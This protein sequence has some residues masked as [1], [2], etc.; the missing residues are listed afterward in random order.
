MTVDLARVRTQERA[1]ARFDAESRVAS[2]TSS[3]PVALP[4]EASMRKPVFL[5]LL[6]ML[7]LVLVSAAAEAQSAASATITGR[8]TDPQGAV[9]GSVTV[10]AV[11]TETGIIRS[12]QTTSDGLYNIPNLAP[13]NYNVSVQASGF[14]KAAANNVHLDVGDSRDVN[15]ALKVGS[16]TT[17]VEVSG[18]VP[19]IETTKTDV[20]MVVTSTDIEKLPV[21]QG[22]G[23]GA[24]DYQNLAYI[25]PGVKAD[26]ST[27]TNGS[28]LGDVI[29]PGSLN[30]R[31]N[32]TFVDGGNVID[33]VDSGRDG[34][35]ASVDEVDQFQVLTNNY[36]AEYGQAGGVILNVN[37]KSGKNQLHGTGYM[38]FRGRNLAASNFFYNQSL[39]LAPLTG[40]TAA[41]GCKDLNADGTLKDLNGC[42]R[43]PFHRKEGGFTLGGPLVKDRVFWF[44][45]FEDV[46]AGAPLILNPTP[47]TPSGITVNSPI[48][49]LLASGR[50]DVRLNDKNQLM[51]RYN[52]ERFAQ[53]NTTAQIGNAITPDSLIDSLFHSNGINVAL[54]SSLTPRLV[55]EARFFRLWYLTATPDHTTL[56]GEQFASYYTGANFL[57]PQG[58][59]NKRYQYLDNLTWTHGAHQ[60]KTGFN[61][62]YYP[63]YSLFTQFHFGQYGDFTGCGGDCGS[64]TDFTVGI[65]PGQVRSKDNI[66]GF[67]GQDTWKV[68]HNL[69]VNYG[70]RYD[71]EAGA[72]RGGP[73]NG[74][75]SGCQQGNAIIPACSSDKNNFQ[76]RVG[77]SYSVGSTGRTLVKGGF[78]EVTFLAYNNVVLDSRNFD[79]ENLFTAFITD[80]TVL[81]QF[82][83]YPSAASLAPFLPVP[84]VGPFGRVRPIAAN[85]KNPEMRMVNF[86][87][88]HQFTDTL[89][90]EVDYI[91]QFGSG[92]FGERDTNYPVVT[93]DPNHSGFSYFASVPSN[94]PGINPNDRPDPRFTNIRTQENS[95]K[96]HYNGLI[97]SA[98]KRMSNHIQF[99]GSYT[100]SH[101]LTN[102]EDFFGLSEPGDPRNVGADFGPAFNDARHALNF[103]VV[104]DT[105]KLVSTHLLGWA[106]NDWS[107]DFIGQFQSG[108]P[109]PVSTG[110]AAFRGERFFGSGNETQQRPDLLPDGTLVTN[111]VPS[112]NGINNDISENGAA[113][114]GCG[115]ACQNTWVAPAGASSRG[116]VDPY[117]GDIVDFKSPDGNLERNAGLGPAFGRLDFSIQKSF[118]FI[119]SHE[120]WRLELRAD[121]FN[122]LN[123]SNF[124][125][126]N[127]NPNVLGASF[128][129]VTGKYS[130]FDG[131]TLN[132][133]DFHLSH[134]Q[135]VRD[136]STFQPGAASIGCPPTG[137]FCGA[138]DP[139]IA[140]IPR[141]IQLS[142]HVRF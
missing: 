138:G 39:F 47:L 137:N 111:G 72:F 130:G 36:N 65:G 106:A 112:Y 20:S 66:Y 44:V 25:A 114:L 120:N 109:Y 91:G 102:G 28:G 23:G 96:S 16:A 32:L 53:L 17:T 99:Q 136:L 2:A 19:L 98:T 79:G 12:G 1:I 7:V 113:I 89:L 13:G 117:S 119:P 51:A 70:L 142:F 42:P 69:T 5:S 87:I 133:S 57:G 82:P 100:W 74:G 8:V 125:G 128:D 83:N 55:N 95:R 78:G 80:P 33:Q 6:A 56:P 127:T 54:V 122:L 115:T 31:A 46:K 64:P 116:P 43:A 132:I 59:W 61:V 110:T 60:F 48:K 90:G 15:F 73:I 101:L 103:G 24:N 93:P 121:F 135:A 38:Y 34:L 84:G 104:L 27:L 107:L 134:A 118:R 97:V 3:I 75:P 10:T 67:Y 49:N 52:A 29:G 22:F 76:P 26:T 94:F 124:L 105:G 21:F 41:P 131:R 4:T 62:S 68:S 63:W 50:L 88:Q 71:L 141:T 11:N 37:T 85:L 139:A 140:D 108:R 129:P 81:A 30:N 58:G 9:V 92:L 35:G 77:F 14:S 18:E 126:N 123:H 86:G 45:N 40:G